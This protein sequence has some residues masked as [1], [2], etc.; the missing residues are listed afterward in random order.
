M[1]VYRDTGGQ[2]GGSGEDAPAHDSAERD[3]AYWYDLLTEDPAPRREETRGPFEPLIS[4]RGLAPDPVSRHSDAA[5]TVDHPAGA[6]QA[7]A[8]AGAAPD[9]ELEEK[10]HARAR[11]LEQIRDLYLTA[12]AIGERNVDKHFDQLLAQQRE[13][14]SEYFRHS[15]AGP[16]TAAGPRDGLLA[17]ADVERHN[18]DESYHRHDPDGPGTTGGQAGK[19]ESAGVASEPPRAW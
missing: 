12:E 10:A 14:I 3:A 9:E 5:A 17:E 13:L 18:P 16:L 11:T 19:P 4:S 8:P 2:Q 1:Y 7:R 15:A 6:E